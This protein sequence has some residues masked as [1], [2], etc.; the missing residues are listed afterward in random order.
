[1]AINFDK[2]LGI[3]PDALQFRVQRAMVLA[4][5]LANVDTPG[6]KAKDIE[7]G[8]VLEQQNSR[9]MSSSGNHMGSV[10]RLGDG[11]VKY[12]IPQQQS[13][14]GNSV[15]LGVEQANYAENA[16]AFQTSFSFLNMKFKGLARAINGR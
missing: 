7:F 6:F 15:E 12:R 14:D 1:M 3:H 16:L 4:G 5:N 11:S 8:A 2:A 13:T 10:D 9:L